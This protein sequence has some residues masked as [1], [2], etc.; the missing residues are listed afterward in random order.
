MRNHDGWGPESRRITEIEAGAADW[1]LL[2]PVDPDPDA[3]WQ[4]GDVGTCTFWVR[5]QD[6]AAGAFARAWA[7]V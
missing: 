7:I 3:G 4:W 2:W 5:R 1:R 6:L